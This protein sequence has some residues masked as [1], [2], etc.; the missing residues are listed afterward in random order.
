[1]NPKLLIRIVTT[2]IVLVLFALDFSGII[3]KPVFA[4]L[5]AGV[6]IGFFILMRKAETQS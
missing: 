1:M 5:I 3:N 6:F 2:I 4:I